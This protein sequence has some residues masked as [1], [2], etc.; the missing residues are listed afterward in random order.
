MHDR[1]IVLRKHHLS[2]LELLRRSLW[3]RQNTSLGFEKCKL[4]CGCQFKCALLPTKSTL[5]G[6]TCSRWRS[7]PRHGRPKLLQATKG[8]AQKPKW[9]IAHCFHVDA[10]LKLSRW[11]LRQE[12]SSMVVRS[13]GKHQHLIPVLRVRQSYGIGRHVLCVA[14]RSHLLALPFLPLR[15]PAST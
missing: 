11:D 10:T 7:P 12:T 4:S 3:H 5:S 14:P 2:I 1:V 15:S 6:E 8:A 13:I 9:F